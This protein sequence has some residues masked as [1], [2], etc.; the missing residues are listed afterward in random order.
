MLAGRFCTVFI[1]PLVTA[2]VVPA[3]LVDV[4]VAVVVVVAV[5]VVSGISGRPRF[6]QAAAPAH[7]QH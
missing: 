6:L 7:T 4:V 1:G 3:V 2:A 5:L